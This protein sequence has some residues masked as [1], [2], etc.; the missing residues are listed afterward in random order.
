MPD[1]EPRYVLRCDDN[2]LYLTS[3]GY[4][5][6][7][8][9]HAAVYTKDQIKA[10]VSILKGVVSGSTGFPLPDIAIPVTVDSSCEPS[11]LASESEQIP[12]SDLVD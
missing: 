9:Q 3:D 8:V 1:I 6:G 7:S 4:Y 12:V 5:I 10:V 11:V 2:N